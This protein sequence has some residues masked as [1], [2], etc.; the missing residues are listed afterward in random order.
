MVVT[1]MKHAD[2]DGDVSHVLNFAVDDAGEHCC[3]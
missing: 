2:G 1:V 3:S